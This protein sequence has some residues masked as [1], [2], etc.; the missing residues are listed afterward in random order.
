[1]S[2]TLR[3]IPTCLVRHGDNRLVGTRQVPHPRLDGL[4]Q[5]VFCRLVHAQVLRGD[6]RVVVSTA[7]RCPTWL[8]PPPP[9]PSWFA[10]LGRITVAKPS[11]VVVV[12]G[13]IIVRQRNVANVSIN[14]AA[15]H[16]RRT[17]AGRTV[18]ILVSGKKRKDQQKK[19]GIEE[20]EVFDR[21]DFTNL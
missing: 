15:C 1:M 13:I 3:R 9:R 14:E 19:S 4:Q 5:V 7:K 18:G 8:V 2:R 17:I 11:R 10:V 6:V 16:G 20:E 12:P 21:L